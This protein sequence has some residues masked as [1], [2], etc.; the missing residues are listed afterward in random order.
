MKIFG[1]RTN[2]HMHMGKNKNVQL[3]D[4]AKNILF[5]VL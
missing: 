1:W 4:K 3:G 2:P 5:A